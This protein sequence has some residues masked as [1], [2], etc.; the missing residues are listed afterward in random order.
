LY[1]QTQF[2]SDP[3]EEAPAAGATGRTGCTNK[4]NLAADAQGRPSSKPPALALPAVRGQR[5]QTKPIR[6]E[7]A[8]KDAGPRWHLPLPLRAIVRNKANSRQAGRRR[9][10]PPSTLV[11]PA[12]GL[13]WACRTNKPNF[14]TDGQG[15]RY[16]HRRGR[17]A[18]QSQFSGGPGGTRPRGRGPG[19]SPSPPAPSA[20]GLPWARCLTARGQTTIVQGYQT[21]CGVG[22]PQDWSRH[23]T[24]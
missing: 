2:V 13:S 1:K 18:K 8:G 15:S 19:V 3:P 21:C 12:S 7:S 20:P 4:P 10:V 14:S 11:P 17:R 9:G 16:C 24:T 5:R 23:E 22:R 6:P